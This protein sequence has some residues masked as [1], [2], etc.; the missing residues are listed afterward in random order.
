MRAVVVVVTPGV[1]LPG[2][3]PCIPLGSG[4]YAS[5]TAAR[6]LLMAVCASRTSAATT[7]RAGRNIIVDHADAEAH[8]QRQPA[9]AGCAC[10]NAPPATR[11]TRTPFSRRPCQ[12]HRSFRQ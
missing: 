8:P 3:V 10:Q 12:P 11:G 1:T 2:A 5:S 4:H 6:R 7:S 9:S